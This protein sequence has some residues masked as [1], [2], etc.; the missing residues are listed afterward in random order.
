L[1]VFGSWSLSSSLFF[2]L[3]RPQ[4]HLLIVPIL[5]SGHFFSFLDGQIS[6]FPIPW[7]HFQ[8]VG[9]KRKKREKKHKKNMKK[10][11]KRCPKPLFPLFFSIFSSFHLTVLAQ[12]LNKNILSRTTADVVMRRQLVLDSWARTSTWQSNTWSLLL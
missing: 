6:S 1:K 12:Y 3:L 9:Q 7:S 2:H 8:M 4:S 10:R 5:E 11:S